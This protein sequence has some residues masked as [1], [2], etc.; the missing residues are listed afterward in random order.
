MRPRRE[1][2]H[3]QAATIPCRPFAGRRRRALETL[4]SPPGRPPT[5]NDEPGKTKSPLRGEWRINVSHEDL[6]SGSELGNPHRARRSSLHQ[7]ITTSIGTTT[8]T[9]VRGC[10]G[11][12]AQ[13]PARQ[14]VEVLGDRAAHCGV[15]NQSTVT[16]TIEISLHIA[17]LLQITQRKARGSSTDPG[18]CGN[19]RAGGIGGVQQVPQDEHACGTVD[20]FPRARS[21]VRNCGGAHAGRHVLILTDT[22][23][24]TGDAAVIGVPKESEENDLLVELLGGVLPCTVRPQRY[25]RTRG[26]HFVPVRSDLGA[27]TSCTATDNVEETTR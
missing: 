2:R 11:D 25:P 18:S 4:R 21:V 16:R 9:T 26:R 14:R 10:G 12:L 22:H 13:Q 27:S 17:E 3:R 6:R 20:A 23:L 24:G 7:T 15:A 8:R 19:L 5:I 1:V